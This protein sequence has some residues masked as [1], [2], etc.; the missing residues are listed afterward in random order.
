[1]YGI[2][3]A[4]AYKGQLPAQQQQGVTPQ[5][6]DLLAMQKVE[7]DKKAAAQQMALASGQTPPTVAQSMEQKAMQSA[8]QEVAQKLGLSGM[9]QQQAQG[10]PQ[11]P[12]GPQGAPQA[13]P[14][15]G[16]AS[17]GLATLPSNLPRQY[18]GGGIVAFGDG[19]GTDD[20]AKWA[21]AEG[22]TLS[23]AEYKKAM[24]ERMQ[25]QTFNATKAATSAKMAQNDGTMGSWLGALKNRLGINPD[26]GNYSNE[27]REP[28]ATIARMPSPD[29]A[30]SDAAPTI[31]PQAPMANGS[32]RGQATENIDAVNQGRLDVMQ[33]ELR[34]AMQRAA[35][36]P[37]DKRAAAEVAGLQRE[38]ARLRASPSVATRYPGQG[39]GAVAANLPPSMGPTAGPD[40]TAP[41][42]GVATAPYAPSTGLQSAMENSVTSSLG[43]TRADIVGEN[44]ALYDKYAAPSQKK[45][46]DIRE[47]GLAELKKLQDDAKAGRPSGLLRALQ[48]M[49]R[50]V[51][52]RTPGIG[53]AFEGVSEGM[54]ATNAGYNAQDMEALKT[55]QALLAEMAAAQAQ[56]DIG[57]YKDAVGAL[58]ENDASVRGA[59][60]AGASMLNAQDAAAARRD[61][62]KESANARRDAANIRAENVANGQGDKAIDSAEK[63]ASR[64]TEAMALRDQLKA[65]LQ[66]GYVEM[67]PKAKTQEQI[68]SR[69]EEIRRRYYLQ[70]GVD[71]AAPAPAAVS[72]A[73]FSAKLKG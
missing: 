36:D 63:A 9:I 64:D 14:P 39:L 45:L 53:G 11:M 43:R 66:P 60:A 13:G 15:Q 65:M 67:N 17:G 56:N 61:A 73:G 55:R 54:D 46:Q 4:L 27:A 34:D 31:A 35:Q 38:M 29:S 19:G 26:N 32:P 69:L 48:L 57:R 44:D 50:N 58:K 47:S 68:I 72:T 40:D 25:Q 49:G 70:H 42:A 59:Q 62:A 12:Q 33:Q 24:R 7:A 5:L 37:T 51:H 3:E 23:E 2:R 71:V 52:S 28:L 10:A 22:D 8:R 41:A 16:M 21:P 6:L 30:P 20:A 18:A 1:M